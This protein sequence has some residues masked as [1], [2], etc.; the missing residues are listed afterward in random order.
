M[1]GSVIAALIVTTTTMML[2]YSVQSEE[3]RSAAPNDWPRAAVTN[4]GRATP[5]AALKS[6]LW[7]ISTGNSNTIMTSLSPEFQAKAQKSWQDI[8]QPSS[9]KMRQQIDQTQ[10]FRILSMSPPADTVIVDLHSKGR[11][12]SRQYS[13]QKIGD[14]W[15]CNNI[16]SEKASAPTSED[17]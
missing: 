8:F 17:R 5:E 15:K 12:R 6:L 3:K 1:V 9:V 10:G 4:A 14:E 13:F 11:Q 7:A 16:W 2:H